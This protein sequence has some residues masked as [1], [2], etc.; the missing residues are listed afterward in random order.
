MEEDIIYNDV[1]K[2][3]HTDDAEQNT[4]IQMANSIF[5]PKPKKEPTAANPFADFDFGDD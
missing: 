2:I 1:V 3:E 5:T 4:I